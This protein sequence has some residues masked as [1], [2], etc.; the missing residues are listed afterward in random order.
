MDTATKERVYDWLHE[1]EP[2]TLGRVLVAIR[3][4]REQ[5]AKEEK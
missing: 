1:H 3:K 4:E 5:Q 2:H